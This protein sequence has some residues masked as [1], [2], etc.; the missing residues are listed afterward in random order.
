MKYVRT[1]VV[2]TLC[3]VIVESK[4]VRR[5]VHLLV[6]EYGHIQISA[7]LKREII[8]KI[9]ASSVMVPTPINVVQ[10]LINLHWSD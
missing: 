1:Y 5:Y 10:R 9:A 8:E 7:N 3:D 4:Y 6:Y 2:C